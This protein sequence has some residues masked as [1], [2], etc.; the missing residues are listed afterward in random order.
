LS[1]EEITS[2]I[3]ASAR[4]AG[5]AAKGHARE[6]PTRIVVPRNTDVVETALIRKTL[7]EV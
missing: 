7:P 6:V 3:P 4:A 5:W 2:R 1:L